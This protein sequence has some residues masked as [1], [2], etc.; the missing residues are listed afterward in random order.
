VTYQDLWAHAPDGYVI[1]GILKTG[2]RHCML[3]RK[4][5]VNKKCLF[6]STQFKEFSH[7]AQIH[8]ERNNEFKWTDEIPE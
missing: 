3:P 1:W 8:Y 5:H 7:N 4:Q 6:G 2:C